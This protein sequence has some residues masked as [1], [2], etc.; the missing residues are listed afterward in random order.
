VAWPY[1]ALNQP[2]AHRNRLV[3]VIG[4]V[5]LD[6]FYAQVEEVENPLLKGKPV[7]VCVYSGRTEDSGVV[8]TANY[9]AREFGIKSGVPIVAAK[10]KLEG[11]DA[12]F[13][14]MLRE[15]YETVSERVM[16][17]VRKEVD[18]FEQT[19]IDEAFFD[20][21]SSSGGDFSAARTIAAKIKNS[22]SM[23]ERLTSSV[24]LGRSKV[25]AKV[26]SDSMKPDGLTVVAPESTAA[27]LDPLPA[28]KLYGVGPKTVQ[29]LDGLGVRTVGELARISVDD[30]QRKFG[31]RTAVYLHD[32]AN[33]TDQEPVTANREITQHSRMITLKRDTR[34]SDE[35][36][37]ELIPAVGDLH[38]Q[39]AS[40]GVSF[41]T[42]SAIGIMTDLSTRTRSKTFEKPI[43][44]QATLNEQARI[45]Y[46]EL[47]GSIDKDLRRV[48]IRVSTLSSTEDQTSLSQ[49]Y[50]GA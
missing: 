8:S 21:T 47:V 5:D 44:D 37:G 23:A 17:L 29:I 18:V 15:K 13:I 49:F 14:P 2:S 36:F 16:R 9:K 3:R 39:L 12:I 20:I 1:N 41:R 30:L 27:F 19:G 42:L 24:G 48:G 46:R 7:L 40:S 43:S 45:L 38:R 11:N 32:A 10:R 28:A 25:V 33:G 35:A 31:R 6:Y 50:Q 4:H 34:D 22:I 26:A